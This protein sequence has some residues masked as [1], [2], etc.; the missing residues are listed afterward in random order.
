MLRRRRKFILAMLIL[1]TAVS[2][3]FGGLVFGAKRERFTP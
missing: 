3:A 2:L 1:I